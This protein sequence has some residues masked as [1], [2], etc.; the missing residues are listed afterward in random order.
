MLD[1]A[2]GG[3]IVAI[4]AAKAGASVVANDIDPFCEDAVALNAEVNA[5]AVDFL[6]GD[7][8]DRPAPAADLIVVGDLA[9]EKPVALKVRAWLTAA[10]QMGTAVLIG[11]PSR[12]YFSTDGLVR[13]AEYEVPTTRELEDFAVKRTG[14]WTF[15]D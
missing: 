12:T 13:L 2:T 14:V 15:A 6:A 8:L 9:Y 11:D 5:V 3:G 10:H 1:V 4:A 7:L